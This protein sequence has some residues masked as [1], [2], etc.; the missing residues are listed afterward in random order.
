MKTNIVYIV[1]DDMGYSD[2][3]CYGS[4]VMTPNI[5]KLA[6]NGLRYNNFHVT[7]LCS[8]T[9]ASLLTG[10]NHHS[11]GMGLLSNFDLG[12]DVP[13]TRGKITPS[14][15]TIAEILKENDF[16]NYAVGKW[17]LTPMY[18]ETPAGPFHNWPLGKGFDRYYGFLDGMTDQYVPTLV[19]DNHSVEPA[20]KADYHLS[21]DL[22][23]QGINFIADHSS[24]HPEKPFFLYLAFGA[25]HSPHQVPKRYIE[26]YK[27][28]YSKG[29]DQIRE[30]RLA[31]QKELGIAPLD[32]ELCERNPGVKAWDS[33][34]SDEK[35]LYE[36]FQE[37]Y[38][39]FLTHTDEQI[40]RFIS[41]L[42]AIDQLDNTLIVFLSDNGASQEGEFDGIIEQSSY[43]NGIPTSIE[44]LLPHIDEIGGKNTQPNYPRGWAQVSNTPFKFYKQTTF[45]GGIHVPLIYHYPNRI[46]EKGTIKKQFHHVI[47][48]TPTVLDLAEVTPPETIKGIKQ[49]PL[50][51]VSMQYTFD[52]SDADTKRHSQYFLMAGQRAIW[53]DGWK[54]I[55]FHTKGTPFE[56]DIWSLYNT[57]EDFAQNHDVA[58]TYPEKL[59][60]LQKLWLE[61]A[62]KYN[63]LPLIDKTIELFAYVSPEDKV[64]SRNEITYYPGMSHNLA[65]P[66][67]YNR[68]Y[69]ITIPIDRPAD[70]KNGV[71][72]AH[73]NQYS[74]YTLYIQ[75]SRLIY[76]Y[77]FVGTLY[78]IESSMKVP[79]GVSTVQFE[80]LKTG[81]L[82]GKGTLL[83][84]GENAG[85]VE[86]PNTL[87]FLISIE[88]IDVGRDAYIPVSKNYA[89]KDDFAFSG[90]IQKVEF[91]LQND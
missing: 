43:F 80:F 69:T 72:I 6:Q 29:W 25:Q 68:S 90:K 7:P 79:V 62:E 47:D 83:I 86:M 61:E 41:Y 37:T 89:G 54:A 63:A 33:L 17:H 59:H 56:E 13:S 84:N 21:E 40:G 16:S 78:K 73:G 18:E 34:S 36:R 24:I 49:M 44:S 77:N 88:G 38:A 64:R 55:S 60:E 1:L 48:I 5:D 32:A 30:D 12:P 4:E 46:K 82:Q 8:P 52:H 75:N 28:V 9:R 10:R 31:R 39:G 35:R 66:P 42:E 76:E 81:L 27:G 22:V 2:L 19:Y 85:E 45:D 65:A 87:P 26:Q 3:G 11:V 23:D 91:I 71:L 57:N 14:A 58:S 15:G 70:E 50:H 53:H 51:G 74:G 20:K 67:I